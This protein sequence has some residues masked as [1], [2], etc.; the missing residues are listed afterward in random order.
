MSDCIFCKIIAGQMESQVVYQDELVIA[1][2]DVNP[3]LPV[4]VLVIP[5]EH[6]DHIGDQVP[7][8]VLGRLFTVAAKVAEIKGVAQAGYRVITN[9]GEDGRQTVKH[10]HLHVLG[11]AKMPIHMGPAD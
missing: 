10:L 9:I 2:E 3:Q 4:H 5:R 7:E 11:G 8:A 1:I 6:Y